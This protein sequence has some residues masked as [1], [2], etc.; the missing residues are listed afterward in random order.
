MIEK[1]ITSLKEHILKQAN[2]A[3]KMITNAIKGLIEN[4]K[5]LLEKVIDK[6]EPKVNKN[7]IKIDRLC[8]RTIALYQPE[9]IF[10]RTVFII[11]KMNYD[12][13]RMADNAVT[14][15][16]HSIK[17]VDEPIS[18]FLKDI[19]KIKDV[20]LAMLKDSMK[21]FID[22]DSFLAREVCIRDSEVDFLAN[23][24]FKEAVKFMTLHPKNIERALS[25]IDISDSLERIADL[26]TNIS[27][28]VVYMVEGKII[29]HHWY[30]RESQTKVLFIC[31]ENSLTSQIA[32]ALLKKFGKDEF[33]VV[34]A[35][36]SKGTLN[37]YAVEVMSEVNIYISKNRTKS[38]E[39]ISK[40]EKNFDYVINL[41]DENS[42]EKPLELPWKSELLNWN[43][44]G[45]AELQGSESE[46]LSRAREIRDDI[47]AMVEDFIKLVESRGK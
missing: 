42:Q 8:I 45:G 16:K 11:S 27:E 46:K 38:I 17:I 15:A 3:D 32:E 2:R 28:N 6:Q 41:C 39:D 7:E 18:H 44:K 37:P 5:D 9:A 12:I 33:H 24:F 25:L 19:I 13:E 21:S 22:R 26:T 1:E 43:I 36:I 23:K 10:L 40:F 47:K 14:I 31:E 34:S 4:D 20:A 29:K 30:R 35:G